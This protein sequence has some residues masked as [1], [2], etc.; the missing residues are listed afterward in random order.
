MDFIF[1]KDLRL[2]V[3]IG[4]YEHEQHLPQMATLD[5]K[6][7]LPSKSMFHTDMIE[8][9]I[10]Y[11]QVVTR[12]RALGIS[13][14][15]GLVEYFADRIAAILIDEFGAP[16]IKV[17]VAKVGVISDAGFVGVSI[18]RRRPSSR[19]IEQAAQGVSVQ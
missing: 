11:A 3:R 2:P 12:I 16:W 10:D 8:D 1:I 9:T 15:F 14:H 17:R 6:I 13:R 19:F 18:Q 7:G 4:I 5:L